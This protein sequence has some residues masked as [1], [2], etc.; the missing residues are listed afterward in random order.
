MAQIDLRYFTFY[1]LSRLFV[2]EVTDGNYLF[3]VRVH[4]PV[5]SIV[6]PTFPGRKKA[7]GKN[8]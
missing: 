3:A 2:K 4:Y 7:S 1:L 5:V 8:D 6:R